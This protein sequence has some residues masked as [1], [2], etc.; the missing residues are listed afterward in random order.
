MSILHDF[1]RIIA[2]MILMNLENKI[3]DQWQPQRNLVIN[4]NNM[5]VLHIECGKFH[6]IKLNIVA[7]S[8]CVIL[9]TKETNY[10]RKAY[11][12]IVFLE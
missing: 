9:D 5:T 8:N 4:K 11:T 6:E 7:V 12:Y 10:V 1:T 3:N 2:V